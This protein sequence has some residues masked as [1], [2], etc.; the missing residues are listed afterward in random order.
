MNFRFKNKKITGLLTVIP[1]NECCFDDEI[2]NYNFPLEKSMRLKKIMGYDKH[3]IASADTCVSDLCIHGL[4]HLLET[5]KLRKEDIDALILV[6]QTPDFLLPPTSSIIHGKLGLKSD[7]VCLDI[8]QGCAG[9]I[10]GLI[11]A[12]LLL[13]QESV[14]K[15]ILLNADIL[16]RKTSRRD[17]NSYPLI[18][19]AASVTVVENEPQESSIIANLKV[20]GGQYNALM[21]PAGGLRMPSSHETGL[22]EDSG[23]GNLRSKDNLV[24]D[25][26]NVFNFVQMEVP[27]MIESLLSFGGIDKKNIDYYMFHQPNRFMLE[28]LADQMQIP[29]EKMPSNIVERFGNASSVT[30]PTNISYNLGARLLDEQ[31]K[32]CLAGFGTGL[33]WSSM[34]MDMGGLSFC[35][36]IEY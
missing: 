8:N 11:E 1:R 7:M 9:F 19:D 14:H 35:H 33:T 23:D 17:R 16:S 30:I 26:P 13:G 3:R 31:L 27:P 29:Y 28:K 15:V 5:G 20:D 21:I 24:M 34:L 25:G 22:M 10:I 4:N 32:I 2:A 36:S 12:F 18:G 6:T